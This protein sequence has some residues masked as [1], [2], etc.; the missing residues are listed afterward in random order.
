MSVLFSCSSKHVCRNVLCFVT[1]LENYG[2]TST[3]QETEQEHKAMEKNDK[4][5]KECK[6]S[7]PF[8]L[9]T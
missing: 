1:F 7:G 3:S 4:E 8:L 9:Q 5:E 2:I 6:L